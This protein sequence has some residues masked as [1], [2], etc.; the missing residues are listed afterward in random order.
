M[1]IDNSRGTTMTQL[2]RTIQRW[3]A[4]IALAFQ[5]KANTIWLL[6]VAIFLPFGWVFL[7]LQA[8]P[9]RA[10]VKGLRRNQY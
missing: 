8:E 6:L 5:G 9:V 10:F 4:R 1:P 7:V 3:R 2:V